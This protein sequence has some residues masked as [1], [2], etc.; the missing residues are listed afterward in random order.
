M[1]YLQVSLEHPNF[2]PTNGSIPVII[3]QSVALFGPLGASCLLY[4]LVRYGDT[5]TIKISFQDVVHP[6][7]PDVT[8]F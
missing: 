1:I 6:R 7:I 5:V 4:L 3:V 2:I 8:I